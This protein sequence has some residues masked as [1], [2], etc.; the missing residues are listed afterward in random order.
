MNSND[1][2]Q[3][4]SVASLCAYD[5]MTS[6]IPSITI[7]G[8]IF[9]KPALSILLPVVLGTSVGFSVQG[10]CTNENLFLAALTLSFSS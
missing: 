2:H 8:I 6:Y 3:Q 1:D 7:P 9:E 10:E 5:K 4:S